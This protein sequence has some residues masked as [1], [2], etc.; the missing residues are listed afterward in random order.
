M[1]HL[2]QQSGLK[3][4]FSIIHMHFFLSIDPIGLSSCAQIKARSCVSGEDRPLTATLTNEQ[5]DD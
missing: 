3:T 2:Y 4:D 5:Q 1:Y